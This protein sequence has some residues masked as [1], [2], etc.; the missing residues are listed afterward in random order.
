MSINLNINLKIILKKTLIKKKKASVLIY[1]IRVALI[2][3]FTFDEADDIS[4]IIFI[5]KK[6]VR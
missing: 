2:F 3:Y 1:V 4:F 5:L 6:R